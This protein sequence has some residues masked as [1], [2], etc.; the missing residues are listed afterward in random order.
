M[1]FRV[2]MWVLSFF[3]FFKQKTAYEM[4][5][6]DWSSDVCSSDLLGKG[7]RGMSQGVTG[8]ARQKGRVMRFIRKA[9][10]GLAAL[11]A[12]PLAAQGPVPAPAAK[13]TEATVP[14]AKTQAAPAPLD[15]KDL[16]AWMDGYLPYPL[17]RGRI[18]GAVVVVVR[19]GVVFV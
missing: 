12:L 6:S 14:A 3:F 1:I 5:I 17:E 8:R 18:P 2:L 7:S 9:M 15:P 11:A 19:G 13:T 10:I 4:R 16:E